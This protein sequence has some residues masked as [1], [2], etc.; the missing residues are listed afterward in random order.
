MIGGGGLLLGLRTLADVAAAQNLLFCIVHT[1]LRHYVC[2]KQNNRV[3]RCSKSPHIGLHRL[4]EW[5]K[6]LKNLKNTNK[7]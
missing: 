4:T 7:N 5:L 2:R 3:I 6:N 1:V